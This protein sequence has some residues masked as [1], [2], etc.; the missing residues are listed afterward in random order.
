[1]CGICAVRDEVPGS[2][3]GEGRRREPVMSRREI[4]ENWKKTYMGRVVARLYVMAGKSRVLEG[5]CARVIW[6]GL[7]GCS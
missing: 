7:D 2:T 3:Q 6:M 5:L 4:E 1:M